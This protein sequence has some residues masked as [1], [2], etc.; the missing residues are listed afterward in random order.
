VK[1]PFT[2]D[3]IIGWTGGLAF[4]VLFLTVAYRV[5][6]LS[7]YWLI[8]SLVLA[9]LT[10]AAASIGIERSLGAVRSYLARRRDQQ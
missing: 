10:A 8:V 9:P 3:R 4:C 1:R 5:G 2:I 6:P 7:I